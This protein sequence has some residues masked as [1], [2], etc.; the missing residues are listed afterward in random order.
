[1]HPRFYETLMRLKN[2]YGNP[3]V[4]ITKNGASFT[5]VIENGKVHDPLRI[6]FLE[7]YM[8][9][10]GDAQ[11]HFAGYPMGTMSSTLTRSPVGD[12][13]GLGDPIRFAPRTVVLA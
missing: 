13:S 3:R 10:A 4:Y 12:Y 7:S 11:P 6:A 9:G 2:E 5:D 8:A 1:M